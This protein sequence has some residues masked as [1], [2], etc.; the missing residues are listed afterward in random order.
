MQCR[1]LVFG[2][3]TAR[4]PGP[5]GHSLMAGLKIPNFSRNHYREL[6]IQT[7]TN[8]E[9]LLYFRITSPFKYCR[10]FHYQKTPS[11]LLVMT[12]KPFATYCNCQIFIKLGSRLPSQKCL[13]L[14]LQI[15]KPR[16]HWKPTRNQIILLPTLILV[17]LLPNLIPREKERRKQARK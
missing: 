14:S 11:K 1:V 8:T 16:I 10:I 3:K 5:L 17:N 6:E 2:E 15:Q 7:D 13:Q 12:R 4:Y 9:K